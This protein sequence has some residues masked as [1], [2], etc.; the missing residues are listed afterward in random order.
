[1]PNADNH[2]CADTHIEVYSLKLA[3]WL[4]LIGAPLLDISV[5]HPKAQL[6]PH[7]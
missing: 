6:T 3:L 5:P 4:D 2:V 1:M 7:N